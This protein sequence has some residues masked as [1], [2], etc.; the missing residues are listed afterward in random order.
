[1]KPKELYNEIVTFCKSN[2]NEE[3]IKKYSRYFK[4]GQYDAYGLPQHL[5]EN[6]V[7]EIISREDVDLDVIRGTSKLL[8]SSHKYEEVSFAILFYK[9]LRK[10][11]EKWTFEDITIWFETGI[12]NWAHCDSIC[13]ELIFPLILKNVITI[14]DLK[15]WIIARNKFQRRAVAVSII[16]ILKTTKDFLPYFNL[17]EPLMT[18]PDREVHQGVGWFLREAWK[19]EKEQTELFLSEWKDKSPRLIFQYACE[20][21]NV[22]EKARFKRT[23]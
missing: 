21:M 3:V 1:M 10:K 6:K 15:P 19:K 16:K 20:R 17:I 8:V 13:G 4:N 7:N 9:S 18:D 14:S 12:N 22:D 5:M 2:T 23:K 11:H